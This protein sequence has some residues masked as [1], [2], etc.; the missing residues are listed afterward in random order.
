MG[1]GKKRRK[2]GT[3]NGK[4]KGK[5]KK[6]RKKKKKE[7]LRERS[8]RG[9]APTFGGGHAATGGAAAFSPVSGVRPGLYLAINIYKHI[10]RFVET[11]ESQGTARHP[12]RPGLSF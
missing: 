7:K 2:K 4:G 9:D 3:E 12:R 11:G 8:S 1:K 10:C 6:K 5:G